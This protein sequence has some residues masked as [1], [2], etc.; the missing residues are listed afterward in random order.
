MGVRLDERDLDALSDFM[1]LEGILNTIEKTLKCLNMHSF[2]HLM[3][4]MMQFGS[5][6]DDAPINLVP[7]DKFLVY[8]RLWSQIL[9]RLYEKYLPGVEY[10]FV[11]KLEVTPY[12]LMLCA[13]AEDNVAA[14]AFGAIEEYLN[15]SYSDIESNYELVLEYLNFDRIGLAGG[16]KGILPT[17]LTPATRTE[18]LNLIFRLMNFPPVDELAVFLQLYRAVSIQQLGEVSSAFTNR[19]ITPDAVRLD[20]NGALSQTYYC[21]DHGIFRELGLEGLEKKLNDD[22]FT[23]DFAYIREQAKLYPHHLVDSFICPCCGVDQEMRLPEEIAQ[24]MLLLQKRELVRKLGLLFFD[25]Y[26]TSY[27]QRL[28]EGIGKFVTDLNS[29]KSP[30][31]LILVEGDTEE[32][33]IPIIAL[34]LG[35]IFAEHGIKVY[36][37][38]TKQKLSADFFS[39]MRKFPHMKLVCLL[40]SDAKKEREEIARKV[41]GNK[42]KYHLTYIGRG[43]FE[44]LF[45]FKSSIKVL[46]EIYPE[47]EEI[48]LDDF[49]PSKTFDKNADRILHEK[50]KAKF[51]KVEFASKISFSIEKDNIPS[52]IIE[53]IESAVRLA[54]KKNFLD[55]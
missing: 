20:L 48:F 10:E 18:Q 23:K 17:E 13:I 30:R 41:K 42:N 50:K 14:S 21:L 54:K 8:K 25:K 1:P 26:F 29:V 6:V 52:E 53:V 46:N 55:E 36:N 19:K 32:I 7:T 27:K 22:R 24:Y 11:W 37:S 51:N 34:R 4:S 33:S 45:D 2:D 39:N 3:D 43:A 9:R 38:T 49:D 12:S 47:G 40:D 44:D 28:V 16:L 31:C 35:I 5:M 15:V